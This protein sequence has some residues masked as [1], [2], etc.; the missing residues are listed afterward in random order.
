METVGGVPHIG[1]VV[2]A[3]IEKEGRFLIARRPEGKSLASFWEFPG[4]KVHDGETRCE[5]LHREIDEELATTIG[6]IGQ[7]T[8]RF[9][10]YADFSLTLVPFRCVLSG[11]EPEPLEHEELRWITVGEIVHYR[12]PDA[13]LPVLDEYLLINAEGGMQNAEVKKQ[14]AKSGRQKD[15]RQK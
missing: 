1:D 9:H 7:L 12:F 15:K 10:A 11:P 4:G 2:C 13:D 3:I 14:K 5:A 8:P 6:V